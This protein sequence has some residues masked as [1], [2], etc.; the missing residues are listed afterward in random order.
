MFSGFGP[1][2]GLLVPGA[3]VPHERGSWPG[4]QHL[5][6]V[7]TM[8]LEV[9]DGDRGVEGTYESGARRLKGAGSLS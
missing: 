7:L 2:D 3:C 4:V 6:Q 5:P 9:A 8:G 1:T